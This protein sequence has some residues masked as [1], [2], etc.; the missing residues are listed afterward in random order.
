MTQK[1]ALCNYYSWTCYNTMITI[2]WVQTL[3]VIRT[4][5]NFCVCNFWHCSFP[6]ISSLL[7]INRD[8][9][10]S[11]LIRDWRVSTTE[12]L[13]QPYWFSGSRPER[14]SQVICAP[15]RREEE[16]PRPFR[17]SH[18]ELAAWH[19]SECSGSW[20]DWHSASCNAGRTADCSIHASFMTSEK[21]CG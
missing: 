21:R 15:P 6:W 19:G 3:L 17:W 12:L 20:L 11:I 1:H 13:L 18:G 14:A 2:H 5:L 16:T 10:I 7:I 9:V 8:L 4:F